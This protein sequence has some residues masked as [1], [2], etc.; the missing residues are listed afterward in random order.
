VVGRSAHNSGKQ[1]ESHSG[2]KIL[3]NAEVLQKVLAP[4]TRPDSSSSP[5]YCNETILRLMLP[6]TLS[7]TAANITLQ[8]RAQELHRRE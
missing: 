1:E 4:K 3:N 5:F 2:K 8:R 7:L 6:S